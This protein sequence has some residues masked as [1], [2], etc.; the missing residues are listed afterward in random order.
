MIL[1]IFLEESEVRKVE[2]IMFYNGSLLRGKKVLKCIE[3]GS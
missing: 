3:M 2:Y 1:P